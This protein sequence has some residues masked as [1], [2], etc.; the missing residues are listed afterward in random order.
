MAPL[1][2][3]A[4]AEPTDTKQ[5]LLSATADVQEATLRHAGDIVTPIYQAWKETLKQGGMTW[6]LFQS[7]ATA[8]YGSWRE[9]LHGQLPWNTALIYF[10]E[11]LNANIGDGSTSTFV[12]S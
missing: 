10:V 9:W 12:L 7:A 8:N 4:V 1:S 5:S 3:P 2:L 6:N 11:K